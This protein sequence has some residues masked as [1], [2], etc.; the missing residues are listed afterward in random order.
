MHFKLTTS[1]RTGSL[2]SKF[3]RPPTAAA[4]GNVALTVNGGPLGSVNLSSGKATFTTA[5]LP[6]GTDLIQTNYGGDTNY[7]GSSSPAV[8]VT[9]SQGSK[10]KP[11]I[12]WA[13]PASIPYGTTLSGTQLNAPA[14]VAGSFVYSPATGTLLSVGAH[15]LSTTFTPTD[16]AHYNTATKSVSITVVSVAG[17]CSTPASPGVIV[18][19][20]VNNSTVSSTVRA[21]AAATITGTLARRELWVDGATKYTESSSKLLNTSVTLA[22]GKHHFTFYAVNTVGQKWSASVYSTVK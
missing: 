20:P 2:P 1:S 14:S 17:S 9:V 15:T 11:T 21:E 19:S 5:A 7:S 6:V 4:T 8:K 18:C 16:T 3:R 22:S 10:S 12:T 13:N